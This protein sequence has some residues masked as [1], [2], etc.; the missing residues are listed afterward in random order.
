MPN[1][2]S[3]ERHPLFAPPRES[4]PVP[5]ARSAF[6]PGLM[7]RVRASGSGGFLLLFIVVGLAIGLFGLAGT[8]GPWKESLCENGDP[9]FVL[10]AMAFGAVF[11]LVALRMLQVVLTAAEQGGGRRRKP[12]DRDRPWTSDYPWRPDGMLPDYTTDGGGSILG[13]VAILALLG[14]FNL[15]FT[16]PSP[17]LLRGIVLLFDLL[18]LAILYDGLHQLWQRLRFACPTIRWITFPAFTG[19]KLEA[20]VTSRRLRP[21]GPARAILR[22]VRDE[23]VRKQDGGG[24]PVETLEPFVHFEQTREVPAGDDLTALPLSFDVP[25]DLPSTDLGSRLARY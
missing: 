21:T 1:Q 2:E 5:K 23:V 20:I 17:L 24:R 7:R 22:F 15:V 8:V 4:V 25:A 18:G 11:V 14:L 19:G 6:G 10:V 3:R 16:S 12:R 13:R 9:R